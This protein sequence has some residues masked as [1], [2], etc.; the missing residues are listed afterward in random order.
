VKPGVYELFRLNA[1][2][3]EEEDGKRLIYGFVLSLK[4]R[5]EL[6][7]KYEEQGAYFDVVQDLSKEIIFKIDIKHKTMQH[8]SDC[9]EIFGIPALVEDFPESISKGDVIHPE[10]LDAYMVYARAMAAGI[11][12]IHDVRIKHVTGKYEKYRILSKALNDT[13]GEPISLLGKLV[14]IQELTEME[15]RANYDLLTHTM[16]KISFQTKVSE[17]LAVSQLTSKHAIY[18]LDLDDFKN[19]NDSFG[20]EFGDYLLETASKRMRNA[21]REQDIIGRVGGDEFVIFL[22]ACGDEETLIKRGS[23]ILETIGREYVSDTGRANIKSSIG[24]AIYPDH[25]T[26]YEELYRKADAALY[27]SK[28]LGKNTV[29]IYNEEIAMNK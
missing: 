27:H 15:E 17:I 1:Y 25:G 23:L 22:N 29:T 21:I 12:G 14:N 26:T 6:M 24:I 8:R 2:Y 18:F 10:D 9:A 13:H 4:R 7:E 11:G 28:R 20:H 5:L 19:V 16:N 3:L